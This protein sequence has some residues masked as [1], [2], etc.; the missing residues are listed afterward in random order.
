MVIVFDA[1]EFLQSLPSNSVPLILTDVPY[2]EVKSSP[3]TWRNL[4]KGD[5]D[6][7]TFDFL[8]IISEC[9]RVCSGS[10]YIFCGWQQLADGRKFCRN[11]GYTDRIC[12][13]EKTNPMPLRGEFVW[14]SG[15]E[16]CLFFRKPKATFNAHCKNTVWRYPVAR[17]KGHP[18]PKPLKLFRYLIS[19][20]SNPGDLVVDPFCGSGT[21]GV[22][23]LLEGRDFQGCDINPDYVLLSNDRISGAY[24][25]RH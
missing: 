13:Y 1:L 2:G 3:C 19:V 11:N 4:D 12:I 10:T 25:E 5:A 14:L 21:T 22:A 9:A 7:V 20:S 8:E 15:V 23:A 17:V 6:I 24:D 18:T 16:C